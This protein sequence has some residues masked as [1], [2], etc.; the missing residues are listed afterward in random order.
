M[1]R[2]NAALYLTDRD[3]AARYGVS[4]TTIWRWSGGANSNFPSPRTLGP[5][6]VRWHIR[7]LEAFEQAA[8]ESTG[9]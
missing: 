8:S 7:D 1:A 6:C 3:V 4:K 9:A 5:R 2:N